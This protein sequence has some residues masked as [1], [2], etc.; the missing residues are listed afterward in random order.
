[1]KLCSRDNLPAKVLYH[2]R[3]LEGGKFFD[4]DHQI[5]I[6]FRTFANVLTTEMLVDV[7]P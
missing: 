4:S 5:E 1:M 3:Y 7:E 6:M 2:S